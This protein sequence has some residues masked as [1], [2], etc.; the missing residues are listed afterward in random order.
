M[1][2]AER[3]DWRMEAISHAIENLETSLAYKVDCA[4][5]ELIRLE[6]FPRHWGSSGARTA[7]CKE[8][9]EKAVR[10]LLADGQ[11]NLPDEMAYVHAR[12]VGGV[13]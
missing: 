8:I 5:D 13:Q 1:N 3:H 4:L 6:V 2:A 12:V 7:L 11:C 10:A 9:A